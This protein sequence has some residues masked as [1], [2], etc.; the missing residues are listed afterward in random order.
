MKTFEFDDPPP[1]G[2]WIQTR[3]NRVF[4]LDR[5]FDPDLDVWPDFHLEDIAWALSRIPRYNGHTSRFCSV[6]EHSVLVSRWVAQHEA[7]PVARAA[8]FHDATEAYMGD[9]SAPLKRAIPEFGRLEIRLAAKLRRWVEYA[10]GVEVAPFDH[11]AIKD[12]DRRI[13]HDER[14]ALFDIEAAPW[15]VPGPRLGVRI[16][17]FPPH[18]ACREFVEAAAALGIRP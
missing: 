18:V 15:N 17:S 5:A 14:D 9:M 2:P 12:A 13:L 8:L 1:P 4:D 11:P 10:F 16:L 3:S 6:A 7:A